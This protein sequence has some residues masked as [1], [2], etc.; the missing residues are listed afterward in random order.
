M[1]RTLY[2]SLS[3][4]AAIFALGSVDSA[5]A[6]VHDP[7][8]DFSWQ[9]NPNGVWTYGFSYSLTGTLFV[10]PNSGIWNSS[11]ELTD[12]WGNHANPFL[13]PD[14]WHTRGKE[15]IVYHP[16]PSG[17]YVILR[18]TAPTTQRYIINAFLSNDNN[19]TTD[20]HIL[21]NGSLLSE[22]YITNSLSHSYMETLPMTTGDVVDFR[23]GDGGNGFNYDATALRLRI[24]AVPNSVDPVTVSGA[25][26]LQSAVHL[27]QQID[28]TFRPTTG[29][30]FTRSVA[31]DASGSYTLSNI[32]P[33]NYIVSIK[34][35]KW[36]RKNISVDARFGSVTNANTNLLAGDA[37]N[38][39]FADI[40][41]LLLLI[42][43][44]NRTAPNAGF[45]DATDFN[46]DGINDIAD[47]LI[48]IGNYNKQGDL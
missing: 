12:Y 16:G 9:V 10:L 46:C 17:E 4:L 21:K 14:M 47:L 36:M 34:G 8:A 15:N 25:I 6:Q 23:L 39:N 41:D 27:V 32:P 44:Y 1:L 40:S 43:H 13:T 28:L 19:A 18:W 7:A 30:P 2:R 45:L 11:P 37:N 20:I 22:G 42:A 38:D 48:L 24:T 26:F 5:S 29:S 31:L 33:D 3:M 35:A